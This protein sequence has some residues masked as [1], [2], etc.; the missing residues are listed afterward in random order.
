MPAAGGTSPAP[1]AAA[2]GAAG[3]GEEG[4]EAQEQPIQP[5]QPPA[6]AVEQPQQGGDAQPG[7]H[8]SG[9]QQPGQ[10]SVD[11]QMA[12]LT[13]VRQPARRYLGVL[14]ELRCN[15]AFKCQY[16]F[17][18]ATLY[19]GGGRDPAALARARDRAVIALRGRA[20]LGGH[21]MNFPLSSYADEDIPDLTG[22]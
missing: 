12:A 16:G 5:S 10:P 14:Q 19:L 7:Q 1:A 22:V 8:S 20:K 17:K 13:G 21:P 11:Q 18:G 4:A 9:Q 6:P 15:D 2:G 3:G